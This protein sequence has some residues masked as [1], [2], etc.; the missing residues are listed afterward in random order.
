MTFVFQY[1]DDGAGFPE[2]L[3]RR[4]SE[5]SLRTIMINLINW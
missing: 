4:E 2:G 5:V 1:D 3:N